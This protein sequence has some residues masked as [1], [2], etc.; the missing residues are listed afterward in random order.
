MRCERLL[1][2]S[3]FSIE[4]SGSGFSVVSR[5]YASASNSFFLL[6]AVVHIEVMWWDGVLKT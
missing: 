2:A 5:A 1:A 6:S 4:T 3:P